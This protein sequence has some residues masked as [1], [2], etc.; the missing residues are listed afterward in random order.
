M[1]ASD[2]KSQWLK[3]KE[4]PQQGLPAQKPLRAAFDMIPLK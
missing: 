2:M 1:Q 4:K 3:E